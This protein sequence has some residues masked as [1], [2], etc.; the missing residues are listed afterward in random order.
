MKD[1]VPSDFTLNS[2]PKYILR[3]SVRKTN[4]C[5]AAACFS[6]TLTISQIANC[7]QGDFPAN[8][9]FFAGLSY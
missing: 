4:V 8:T 5:F 6:F 7:V 3:N 2:R 1:G 9:S